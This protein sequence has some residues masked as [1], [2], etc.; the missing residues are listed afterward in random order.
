MAN[1]YA[2]EA[3]DSEE[4]DVQAAIALKDS[5]D[6]P[7][8]GLFYRAHF[9]YPP[10]DVEQHLARVPAVVDVLGDSDSRAPGR[11]E[12]S[13]G[14]ARAPLVIA[15]AR[16]MACAAAG[17]QH[18]N[19]A[20]AAASVRDELHAALAARPADAGGKAGGLLSFA[21]L[22]DDLHRALYLREVCRF[23]HVL[24]AHDGALP[25]LDNLAQARE[26]NAF[27]AAWESTLAQPMLAAREALHELP[28]YRDLH[29]PHSVRDEPSGAPLAADSKRA[30][31][32]LD[33]LRE[34]LRV[35]L[36][37]DALATTV[38]LLRAVVGKMQGTRGR[39]A[40]AMRALA[41][42]EADVL[43]AELAAGD[44]AEA[45][46]A[47]ADGTALGTVRA[48][49]TTDADAAA[50]A[51]VERHFRF[52]AI[53][54]HPDKNGGEDG[55]YVLLSRAKIAL[56]DADHARAYSVA[57]LRLLGAQEPP[58]LESLV[59]NELRDAGLPL[60]ANAREAAAQAR[61]A[62][63]ADASARWL[64][65]HGYDTMAGGGRAFDLAEHGDDAFVPPRAVLLGTLAHSTASALAVRATALG[66]CFA[67][68][69]ASEAALERLRA[70]DVGARRAQHAERQAADDVEMAVTRSAKQLKAAVQA[71]RA[72]QKR[73]KHVASTRAAAESVVRT[74]RA[75]CVA[76]GK[77][78]L[79]AEADVTREYEK[80]FLRADEL[81]AQARKL[82]DARIAAAERSVARGV[83]LRAQAAALSQ[84]P[85]SDWMY[86]SAVKN[87]QRVFA[88]IGFASARAETESE[89]AM[90]KQKAI[91][92]EEARAVDADATAADARAD[93]AKL[94]AD[95][96]W[97]ALALRTGTG[98]KWL[99]AVCATHK[100]KCE[101]AARHEEQTVRALAVALAGELPATRELSA[102]TQAR[103]EA[104]AA[105]AAA[106]ASLAQMRAQQTGDGVAA[107]GSG[108]A[109]RVAAEI[110]VELGASAQHIRC[111]PSSTGDCCALLE[112]SV[113]YAHG[114]RGWRDYA[115]LELNW[116]HDGGRVARHDGVPR[117]RVR[118][119][120]DLGAQEGHFSLRW[121]LRQRP[122][123]ADA[124]CVATS[125]SLPCAISHLVRARS[126][127]PALRARRAL[128]AWQRRLGRSPASGRRDRT[129]V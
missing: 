19:D 114:A 63:L 98:D 6:S 43:E 68:H 70:V 66:D 106:R 125:W 119:Q 49:R 78:F 31:A 113:L 94:I 65:E 110:D 15:L 14:R 97:Q 124:P 24:A 5:L 82:A 108:G 61:G 47:S 23:M 46:G 85:A 37:R 8:D 64:Q 17:V 73:R 75:A 96:D 88:M 62:V 48:P 120:V 123:G 121:R 86:S 30:A 26:L 60:D 112:L 18:V 56:S 39:P 83:E 107:A 115:P 28:L 55:P 7:A 34:S 4:A 95:A 129:G 128:R 38:R 41:A 54:L 45:S 90:L 27:H 127:T 93:A 53:R 77:A 59:E 11:R 42:H 21:M 3:L 117:W 52:A 40:A 122:A 12:A 13:A 71:E 44:P 58:V 74:A 126:T 101:S 91:K 105:D 9:P 103:E 32:A 57:L 1:R 35:A 81:I 118:V 20:K 80:R 2:A 50:R 10:P 92:D 69:E 84:R 104:A 79:A 109:Q 67:V 72:A 89:A 87:V 51:A 99:H 36:A 22:L 29:L 25:A 100:L 33:A 116:P 111:A 16:E 76:A 102:A